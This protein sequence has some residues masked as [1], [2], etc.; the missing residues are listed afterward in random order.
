[1]ELAILAVVLG[2]SCLVFLAGCVLA[3]TRGWR[4]EPRGVRVRSR[5]RVA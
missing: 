5:G 2:P 3:L 4:P 1:M